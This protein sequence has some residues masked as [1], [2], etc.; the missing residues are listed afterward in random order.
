MVFQ[1]HVLSLKPKAYPQSPTPKQIRYG[2][3]IIVSC[4]FCL[5]KA[6]SSEISKKSSI[7]PS[8]GTLYEIKN[9][10]MKVC[11][12]TISVILPNLSIPLGQGLQTLNLRLVVSL[13]RVWE[14]NF[15]MS[16][17]CQPLGKTNPKVLKNK[18]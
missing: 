18:T 16:F 3:D 13:Q 8:N 6:K 7:F 12:T 2:N 10:M 1:Q 14:H 9:Q 17:V 5:G 4:V 15:E 11:S